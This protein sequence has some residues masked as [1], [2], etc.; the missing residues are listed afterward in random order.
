MVWGSRPKPCTRFREVP[1]EWNRFRSEGSIHETLGFERFRSQGSIH[2]TLGSERFRSE[3]SIHETLGSVR[4]R[5]QGSIHE[6]LGHFSK[7]G[8]CL[9]ITCFGFHIA[10]FLFH[11]ACFLL[12]IICQSEKQVL[13]TSC[14]GFHMGLCFSK[15]RFFFGLPR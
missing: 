12:L 13:S 4:F 1:N 11:I 3:G 5:S 14:W 2:E 6:T 15:E 7:Y 9:H 8:M 10:W